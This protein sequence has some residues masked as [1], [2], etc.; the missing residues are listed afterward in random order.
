MIRLWEIPIFFPLTKIQRRLQTFS[1]SMTR[2]G[3]LCTTARGFQ[4]SRIS[5][6]TLWLLCPS[7]QVLRLAYSLWQRL[8][9]DGAYPVVS[10]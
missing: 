10:N 1:K 9:A 5:S 6:L 4:I 7:H 2:M 3:D 8:L